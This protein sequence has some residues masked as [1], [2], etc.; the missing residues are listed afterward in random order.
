M[1]MLGHNNGPTLEGG[2]GW[3]KHCWSKARKQLLPTLPIEVLRLRVKRAKEL[4]LD[5]TTYA[6][7]RATTGHDVVAF[8]FSSNALRVHRSAADM[9]KPVIET[10]GR[11]KNCDRLIAVQ[12]PLSPDV[13]AHQVSDIAGV[14]VRKAFH[15]PL[16]T[17]SWSDIRDQLNEV[18]M[19]ERLSR[20]TVLVVG[21]TALEREWCTAGRMAG[22]L[23]ADRLFTTD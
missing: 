6:S 22:Y 15:A 11:Q 3:R 2:H 20:N 18:L 14:P 7:V 10:L 16:F 9:P 13:I 23:D 12:P 8:L 17:H 5:Y 21:R 1:K 4:G 19:S